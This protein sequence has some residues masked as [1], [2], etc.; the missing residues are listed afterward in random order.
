MH[1]RPRA[2][3]KVSKFN[4]KKTKIYRIKNKRSSDV[5]YDSC[6]GEYALSL[7]QK[8]KI[9]SPNYPSQ[10]DPNLRCNYY[11]KSPKNTKITIKLI[12]V[13]LE[14]SSKNVCVD[15]LEVRYYSLG[16]PGPVLVK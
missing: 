1:G 13:D 14:E 8:L 9:Q 12:D 15:G 2:K 5:I 11:I 7:N 3:I 10:Y 16:Q 6:G 4:Y